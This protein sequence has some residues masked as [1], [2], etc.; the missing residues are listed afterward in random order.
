MAAGVLAACAL[1]AALGAYLSDR[2]LRSLERNTLGQPYERAAAW[3]RRHA[4]PGDVYVVRAGSSQSLTL[5]SDD[6]ALVAD[7]GGRVRDVLVA[8]PGGEG[9]WEVAHGGVAL[10]CM[11]PHD[12]G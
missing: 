10:V 9:A 12:G 2:Q 8:P 4:A 1:A 3:M 5:G 11:R 7:E 6:V